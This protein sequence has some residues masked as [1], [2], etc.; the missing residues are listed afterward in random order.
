M[1]CIHLSND[2][3]RAGCNEYRSADFRR[4]CGLG[5]HL[6]TGLY[7]E[8]K[9]AGSGLKGWRE[10]LRH[11]QTFAAL[12]SFDTAQVRELR[13][14]G[15]EYPASLQASTGSTELIGAA[16]ELRGWLRQEQRIPLGRPLVECAV[17]Y[18]DSAAF[19]RGAGLVRRQRSDSDTPRWTTASETGASASVTP[20]HDGMPNLSG[21]S[22][23]LCNGNEG[24]PVELG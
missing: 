19:Q 11:K 14:A 1:R 8:L 21:D 23:P 12:G 24:A 16:T 22:R 2:C 18:P 3:R 10:L 6:N 15:C 5:R 20:P 9:A 13:E 17:L 7:I 4:R